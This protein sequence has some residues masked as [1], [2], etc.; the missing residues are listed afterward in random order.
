MCGS[1][2]GDDQCLAGAATTGER[3]ALL[4]G[5]FFFV[6]SCAGPLSVVGVSG[7][8][9]SGGTFGF[10]CARSSRFCW[11]FGPLRLGVARMGGRLCARPSA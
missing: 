10:R 6:A 5:G 8:S 7:P 4:R 3:G 11:A 9:V 1:P 2:G